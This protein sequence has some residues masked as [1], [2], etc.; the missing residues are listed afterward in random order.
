MGFERFKYIKEV[1]RRYKGTPDLNELAITLKQ[2]CPK[3]WIK[4]RGNNKNIW[5]GEKR[6]EDLDLS[7]CELLNAETG[8]LDMSKAISSPGEVWMWRPND[9]YEE[10]GFSYLYIQFEKTIRY[11]WNKIKEHVDLDYYLDQTEEWI[12]Q[13]IRHYSPEKEKKSSFKTLANTMLSNCAINCINQNTSI[14]YYKDKSLITEKNKQG[15][16]YEIINGKRCKKK[17]I[18]YHEKPLSLDGI[19]ENPEDPHNYHL[20]KDFDEYDSLSSIELLKEKYKLEKDLFCWS[21]VDWQAKNSQLLN[22][23]ILVKEITK[24]NKDNNIKVNDNF[25]M[26]NFKKVYEIWKHN[27]L[28]SYTSITRRGYF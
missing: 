24:I 2:N 5:P 25:T 10:I 19:I 11:H 1:A 12:C 26:D 9:N 13:T 3:A 18:E 20:P 6:C 27:R 7:K 23:D 22:K 4:V 21:V 8:E 28:R 15:F 14:H 16:V 17:D